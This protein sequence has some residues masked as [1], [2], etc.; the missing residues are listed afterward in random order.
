MSE[1]KPPTLFGLPIVFTDKVPLLKTGEM[2][3]S[4]GYTVP[5]TVLDRL[6]T[7]QARYDALSPEEREK[8]DADVAAYEVDR[9]RPIEVEI[10]DTLSGVRAVYPP[11]SSAYWWAEG[12]GSCDCN[13]NIFPVKEGEPEPEDSGYC[14][15]CQRYLI[16]PT[17]RC[18]RWTN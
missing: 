2:R 12:N 4:G 17:R 14:D 18:T 10:L 3:L 15:G 1:E 13:R 11:T 16:V 5:E 6:R 9:H 7:E 8:E